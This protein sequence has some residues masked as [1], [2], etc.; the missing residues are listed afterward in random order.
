MKPLKRNNCNQYLHKETPEYRAEVRNKLHTYHVHLLM[1][2]V[3]HGLM[4]YLSACHT[5]LV[6]KCFGRWLRT[7]RQGVA[8]SWRVVALAMKNTLDEFLV[9]GAAI[10]SEAKFITE[11][12]SRGNGQAWRDAA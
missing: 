10:N 5:D 4:H 1:G 8:S 3:T 9:V 7:F 11:R 12:Q 2:A 6:W